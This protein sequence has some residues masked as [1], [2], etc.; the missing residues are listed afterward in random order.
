MKRLN[1]WD[2]LL[3]YSETPNI[4]MHT[5]KVAVIDASDYKELKAKGTAA[6]RI[7][8]TFVAAPV[9]GKEKFSDM[10][11]TLIRNATPYFGETSPGMQVYSDA[12]A[13]VKIGDLTEVKDEPKK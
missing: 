8:S 11:G 6:K 3:L 13:A 4:H 7:W 9:Q 2:A 10:V 1:G 12:R 5:L